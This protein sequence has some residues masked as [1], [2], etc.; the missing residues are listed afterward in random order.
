MTIDFTGQ[1]KWQRVY[2]ALKE[3]NPDNRRIKA[4]LIEPFELPLLFERH[5]LAI[6][7]VCYEAR[8]RWRTAGWLNQVYTGVNLEGNVFTVGS[9]TSGVDANSQRIKLNNIQLIVFPQLA[10]NYYLWFDPVHWLPKLSL[11]V[12]EFTGESSE[13]IAE[14]IETLKV[15]VLRVESKVDEIRSR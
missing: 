9:P 4:P 12:W 1:G 14:L 6:S 10:S 5:I 3:G 11:A 2:F 7:A 15:D 8:P 13:P